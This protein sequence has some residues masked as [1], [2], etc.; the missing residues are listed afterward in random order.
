MGS[1]TV[2]EPDIPLTRVI[3]GLDGSAPSLEAG[4]QV[5]EVA[6]PEAR[7]WAASCW[8]PGTAMH[9]GIHAGSVARDLRATCVA[10]LNDASDVLPPFEPILIR[11]SEVAGLLSLAENLQADLIAVGSNGLHG[12]I[13]MV[14]GSVASALSRHAPCSVLVALA[15]KDPEIRGPVVL[16]TDGSVGATIA[17]AAAVRIAAREKLPLV[18]ACVGDDGGFSAASTLAVESDVETTERV[19][20]GHPA[21][22][23]AELARSEGASLLVVGARGNRGLRALGSVSRR[24]VDRAPCSTLIVRPRSYP[25][26][27]E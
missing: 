23:I 22:A 25:L 15:R 12:A 13:G 24:I 8:D 26:R 16:A 6:G 14:T 11:G 3:V 1:A 17:A 10:A 4:R 20:T 2:F 18:V 21:E 19:L 5:P 27:D 7:I 9:A